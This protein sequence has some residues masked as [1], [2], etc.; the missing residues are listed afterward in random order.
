[1][2]T[3]MIKTVLL[4][5]RIDRYDKNKERTLKEKLKGE[6][7][8]QLHGTYEE[9]MEKNRNQQINLINLI[10]IYQQYQKPNGKKSEK[11]YWIK[12]TY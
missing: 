5:K 3:I 4:N 11:S 1:M 6:I 10:W 2:K 12:T 7:G 8:K 9:S